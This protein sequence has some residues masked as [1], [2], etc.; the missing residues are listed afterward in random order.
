M[1][2]VDDKKESEVKCNDKAQHGLLTENHYNIDP[3]SEPSCSSTE[4]HLISQADLSYLVHDLNLSKN[5][6]ELLTS[7]FKG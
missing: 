2:N 6:Y 7:R 4:T 5:Q 3:L 1:C